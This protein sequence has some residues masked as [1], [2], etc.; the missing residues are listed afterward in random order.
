MS[1]AINSL[2]VPVSPLTKTVMS[3]GPTRSTISRSWRIGAESPTILGA[4]T[5][6]T[7]SL[8]STIRIFAPYDCLL[9]CSPNAGHAPTCHG[10]IFRHLEG[11]EARGLS[12]FRHPVPMIDGKGTTETESSLRTSSPDIL[13]E[14]LVIPSHRGAMW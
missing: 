1:E 12:V 4:G 2:P 10:A 9:R 11:T 13:G 6:S 3:C 7:A 8:V 14:R 5:I